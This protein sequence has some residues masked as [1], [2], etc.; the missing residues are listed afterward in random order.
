VKEELWHR[1]EARQAKE[2]KMQNKQPES[3]CTA[4]IIKAGAHLSQAK[5]FLLQA[6]IAAPSS[7][8]SVRLRNIAAASADL[9]DQVQ[10]ISRAPEPP[11]LTSS[12]AKKTRGVD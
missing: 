10:S 7:Q 4:T 6:A 11:C 9:V 12:L 8:E 3:E 5:L 1:D 2:S